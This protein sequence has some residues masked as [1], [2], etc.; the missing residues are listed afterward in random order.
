MSE[1]CDNI[2]TFDFECVL[3]NQ[4]FSVDMTFTEGDPPIPIDL[5]QY[6]E[7]IMDIKD[8]YGKVVTTLDL[9]NG[10]SII[11]AD[12]NVLSIFFAQDLTLVLT[13]QS[14]FYDI[15]FIDGSGSNWYP[16]KGEITVK[17]TITRQ[18]ST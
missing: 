2:G 13:R 15:L 10:L 6:P 14:Y 16:I 11:G 18:L 3:Q 17:R 8:D 7:I 4:G 12:D 9:S 1:T 5:T